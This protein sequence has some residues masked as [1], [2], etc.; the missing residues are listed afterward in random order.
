[1]TID[2][3][4]IVS[5]KKKAEC[6]IQHYS[7]VSRLKFTKPERRYHLRLK[8][9]LN[10]NNKDDSEVPDFTM[11]ELKAAIGKMKRKG[12]PGPDDIP[13]SFLKELGPVALTELLT[14]C[15]QSLH[16]ADCPQQWRNAIIIP[17]LKA[18]KPPSEIGSYRP[19]SLTSCIAKVLERM[20]AERLYFMAESQGWFR[21][22]QAGFRRGH[23]CADQI[24]RISQAIEDGFQMPKMNRAVMVLLD[25]SKAFDTVWRERLLLSM[26][27][28]GVPLQIVRW[29]YGFL[30]NRQAQV[31]LHN[32]LSTSKPLHQGVPQG[33]VLS[34]LLFLFFINNLAEFLLSEDPERTANLILSLFADDVTILARNRSR[35]VATADAQWAVDR[36][37]EWSNEWKLCLNASKSEVSYFSTYTQEASWTPSMQ[38]NGEPI[39]FNPTPKLLGVYLDRQ[40]SF[41]KHVDEVAK[42]GTSKIKIISAVGNT[43]WGW[44]K[45]HLKKLYFSYVRSKLD[46]A[47]PGWQ[48]WL[49]QSNID[50]LERVQ[51]KALRSV[52]GQIR[53]SPGEAIR[54]GFQ[55]STYETHMNRNI[56]KSMELAKRLP[57]EHPRHRAL[58][59][60]VP[61]KPKSKRTSWFQKGSQLTE[62]FIPLAGES[63]RPIEF[64]QHC[65]WTTEDRVTINS[66]L[67]GVSGRHDEPATIRAAA[68]KAIEEWSGDISIFTD[69]SAVEGC[70]N[71]GSA[72][73][74]HMHCDPPRK[75]TI[76]KKGA[77]FTCS[78]EEEEEGLKSATQW[79]ID[80]CNGSS[81]P[82]IITDSQSI[83][84]ALAGFNKDVDDMRSLLA[85]CPANTRIQW[86]PS[87]CGI[88]GN[89]EADAAAN[90]A[91][92]LPGNRRPVSFRGIIPQIM[93]K[94]SD[95]PCRPKYQHISN[96]YADY[97][98]SK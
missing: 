43:K 46:Y 45:A 93:K 76:H 24:I 89:E 73:V 86:V 56:L 34:P 90:E 15:N 72:A 4:K 94:I 3:K 14:I 23:S 68:V 26:A 52:T 39:P 84:M 6:F 10:T 2:G 21:S 25:Y 75:E 85:S 82:I 98:K 16:E 91:R 47:G 88:E 28:K 78:F 83:C 80:N 7:K 57:D 41:K 32:E 66:H 22:I 58:T 35:D 13:P 60:A 37:V 92:L 65:P 74:V 67:D 87:H 44:D 9:L 95:P 71:G 97:S 69:G 30:Q 27:E 33:C 61:P 8:R 31:R 55:V 79:I 70:M 59:S 17:L 38:I 11:A 42:A 63:R 40:L 5:T 49:S 20:F 62:Q 77:A 1:M 81:R 51:N 36:V 19:V 12:A 64:Y 54:L 96:I 50:V 53:S 48:P 29:I 18:T